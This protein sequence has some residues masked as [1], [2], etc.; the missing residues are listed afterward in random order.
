[1]IV[2][3][4]EGSSNR[5]HVAAGP[6]SKAVYVVSKIIQIASIIRN[7]IQQQKGMTVANGI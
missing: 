1:M 6:I 7:R 2:K 5:E 4:I 3:E